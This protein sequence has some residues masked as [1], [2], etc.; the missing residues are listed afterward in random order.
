MES[1]K[2]F[3]SQCSHAMQVSQVSSATEKK[4]KAAG[5]LFE[6]LMTRSDAGSR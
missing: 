6:A 5:G 3:R 2:S 4:D 1:V